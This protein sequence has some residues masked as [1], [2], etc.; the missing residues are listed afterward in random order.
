MSLLA[1]GF[2]SKGFL[3]VVDFYFHNQIFVGKPGKGVYLFYDRDELDNKYKDIQNSI[4]RNKSFAH[5]FKIIS[6][7]IF[8]D[9]F[10]ICKKTKETNLSEVSNESLLQL[11]IDFKN[12]I[13]VG[14]LIT[15][16][17]WGIEAC[18]DD[19]YILS[20][21]IRSKVSDQ[22]FLIIKGK[23]SQSTGKSV[24]LSEKESFL[25]ICMNIQKSPSLHKKFKS[26][27]VSEISQILE[28]F[29]SVKSAIQ[30]HMTNFEWVN[31]EYVSEKWDFQRWIGVLQRGMNN[32]AQLLLN[33][34]YTQYNNA[35]NE[36]QKI[37]EK[38]ELSD[39]S[40]HVINALNEFISE[41]DWAKGKFCYAL[42]IYDL[43]LQEIAARLNISKDDILYMESEELIKVM[44]TR[45]TI[46]TKGRKDGFALVSK[47]G[48]INIVETEELER[49]LS[50]ERI[51]QAFSPVSR[52]RSFGGVIASQGKVKGRVRIIDN[53]E[54]LSEFKRGEILVTYMTTMEFTSLF[55][56]A[57]G[58]ITD[59]GGLS[60]HAAIISREFGIPCIVGTTIATRTLRTGDL[61]ELN[62]S[63]GKITL[64]HY[65]EDAPTL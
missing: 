59:E 17:L 21:E 45:Q 23:L 14:P 63:E 61:I 18:W 11:L 42:S 24:A 28:E 50:E 4:E 47:Q 26:L 46:S 7:Q 40:I 19:H 34:M 1:K 2:H 39:T 3:P 57:V 13:T 41:R 43:L 22:E 36:K 12:K 62:A 60:S 44:R 64:L 48:S 56:K 58:I 20:R 6:D 31:S 54:H 53:P 27:A 35:I 15:V 30:E 65:E 49:F 25:K 29:P 51:E 5:D 37:I 32:D 38:L 10:T 52:V 9:L 16:Q 33:N 55:G 8:A